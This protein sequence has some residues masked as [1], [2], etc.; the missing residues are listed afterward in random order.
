LVF[1]LDIFLE[2][3]FRSRA[4]DIAASARGVKVFLNGKRLPVKNF[5]DYVDQYLKVNF[6][7]FDIPGLC[8]TCRP[9]VDTEWQD[10]FPH[11]SA[12]LI[13]C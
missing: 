5:K 2:S 10:F 4:F 9:V 11:F 3:L 8:L 7:W 12:V 1:P 13:P 6:Y